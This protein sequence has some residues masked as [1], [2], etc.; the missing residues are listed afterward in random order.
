MF[1]TETWLNSNAPAILLEAS[2]PNY[3]FSYSFR[4]GKKGGGTATILLAQNGFKEILFD[5]YGSFEH[6]SFVFSSPPILCLTIYRPPKRCASFIN[7]FSELLSFIHS[8]YD[9]VLILGDFNLHVDNQSDSF[10]TEFL[11][12][13]NCMNF[14]QHVTQ[15]THNRGHILDLII[16]YGLSAS[17]TSVMDVGLSDHFCVFLLSMILINKKSQCVL[18]GNAI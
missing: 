8:K 9:R 15:P 5:E 17:V 16:T 13:L 7:E 2:P 1:L 18:S 6:H 10:S 14:I 11:N 12:L 4:Q 3:Q